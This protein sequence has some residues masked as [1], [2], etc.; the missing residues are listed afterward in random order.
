MIS[1]PHLRENYDEILIAFKKRNF[2]AKNV[3]DNLL[4]EDKNRR[5][6]QVKLDSKLS[7]SNQLT[8][9]SESYTKMVKPMKPI[10]KE[11]KLKKLKMNP[12]IWLKSF[13]IVS[14]L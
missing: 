7:E 3:I 6:I 5:E 2:D 4:N 9:K 12:K 8:K 1:I 10:K 11:L 13:L 14:R